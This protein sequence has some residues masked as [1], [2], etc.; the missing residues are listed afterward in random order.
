MSK[1]ISIVWT[2]VNKFHMILDDSCLWLGLYHLQKTCQNM[3]WRQQH[4]YL[5]RPNTDNHNLNLRL[6][7]KVKSCLETCCWHR[8]IECW[9]FG[10]VTVVLGNG[11]ESEPL[12]P[13]PLPPE[14]ANT[15]RLMTAIKMS[16]HRTA[17]L[18]F[19]DASL[20]L[21]RSS[22]SFPSERVFSSCAFSKLEPCELT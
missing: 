13:A 1:N 17:L 14:K 21:R 16:T 22:S 10:I 9:C 18:S 15:C 11:Y 7:N 20:E 3:T 6:K 4:S 8:C 19:F 2:A 5:S 12:Y